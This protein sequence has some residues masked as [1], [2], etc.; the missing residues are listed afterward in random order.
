MIKVT[1]AALC[2]RD[3]TLL[4]AE[5]CLEFVLRKLDEAG[6]TLNRNLASA[7]RMRIKQRRQIISG[8]IQYLDDAKAF[9][10]EHCFHGQ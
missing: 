6:N 7:L 3:A 8:V 9:F 1:V 2:H 4:S 10:A 5:A